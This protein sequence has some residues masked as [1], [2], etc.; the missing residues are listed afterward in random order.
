MDYKLNSEC[1]PALRT[2]AARD[3]ARLTACPTPASP[4]LAPDSLIQST[5]RPAPSDAPLSRSDRQAHPSRGGDRPERE[6]SHSGHSRRHDHHGG[7]GRERSSN[8]H[9]REQ[10]PAPPTTFGTAGEGEGGDGARR[11]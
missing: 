9:R 3:A 1:V 6:H 2:T 8:G 11:S 7:G 10:V 4:R 5:A